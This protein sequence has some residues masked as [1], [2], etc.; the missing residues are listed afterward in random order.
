[1]K[2]L[3]VEDNKQTAA[4]IREVMKDH[5]AVDVAYTGED[6]EYQAQVNDYDLIILDLMLPDIDGVTVCKKIRESGIKTPVLIL[7]GKSQVQ[8]KVEALDSGADDYLVKPFSF[9]ELLARVRALLRRDPNSL[10]SNKLS[11]GDLTL[12][13]TANTVEYKGEKV[14]LRRKCF[15]LLEYLMRNKGRVVTRSMILDH[16]W[17]SSIDPVTNTV[18]VH[19]KSLRDKIGKYCQDSFIKTVHGLGY[20]MEAG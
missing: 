11:V 19:I 14:Y 18:D 16:V 4:T 20:K 15:K 3:L 8:D 12:D 9:L 5:Y 13:V 10:V 7:T 2:V 1:V 6:G 17:E